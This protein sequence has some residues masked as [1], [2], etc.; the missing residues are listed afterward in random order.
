MVNFRYFRYL[1]FGGVMKEKEVIE[2][3][4]KL[5]NLEKSILCDVM[6][7]IYKNKKAE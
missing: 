5:S 2:L 1:I 6:K 4:R 7:V 3:L